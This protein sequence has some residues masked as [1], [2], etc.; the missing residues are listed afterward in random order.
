M[1]AIILNGF[2]G[3]ENLAVAE[4]PMP[5][6]K[7]DEVLIQARAIGINPIDA[8]TRSGKGQAP[9][10]KN[11][12]PMILG[13][14]VAGIVAAVG[15]NVT[16]FRDGQEVFGM[17][18]FPGMGKTYAEYVAAPAAQLALKPTNISFEAAA[19]AP[20]AAL[21]AWQA[22]AGL[23]K[24]KANDRV[25]IHAAAGGVGHY[26][27]QIAKYFGAYVIGTSSAR[28]KYFVLDIGADEH[29]D[30]KAQR[31][32]EATNNIDIV[33]DPIGY[34]NIERSL[35]VMKPGGAIITLPVGANEGVTEKAKAK[36]MNGYSMIVHSNGAD[37]KLIA[38][39]MQQGKIKSHVSKIFPFSQVAQAH[40]DV[41]TGTTVGKIVLT[42]DA[43]HTPFSNTPHPVSEF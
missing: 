39:L 35:E 18:N 13:W 2:G 37:M 5:S 29:I 38:D 34:D 30:Y 14:D 10:F 33:L 43:H 41:A 16:E 1:K 22:L 28:N 4:I 23:V 36:G 24:I 21:T 11:A 40:K 7:D 12:D 32:E 3:E 31:F 17:V 27:V 8:K 25:L 9:A 26:A 19:A 20:L 6:I 15:K 42:L